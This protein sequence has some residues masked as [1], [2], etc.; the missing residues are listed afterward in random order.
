MKYRVGNFKKNTLR[1]K[2][3]RR[4][5]R[6]IARRKQRGGGAGEINIYAKLVGTTLS[7]LT[8]DRPDLVNILIP[9]TSMFTINLKSPVIFKGAT[10]SKWGGSSWTN[11][12]T[13]LTTPSNAS[14]TFEAYL[15]Q[16]NKQAQA[17]ITGNEAFRMLLPPRTAPPYGQNEGPL[18]NNGVTTTSI[19]ING[20]TSTKS[21]FGSAREGAYSTISGPS[22]SSRGVNN[23]KITLLIG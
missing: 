19:R 7:N 6:K 15:K 17:Y 14:Y 1:R 20:I 11:V 5:S 9:G 22:S 23:L 18:G 12:G 2:N 4:V 16:W 13:F 8:N 3:N 21:G 10:W